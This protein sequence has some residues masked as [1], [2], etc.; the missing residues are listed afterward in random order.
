MKENKF[1]ELQSLSLQQPSGHQIEVE[2]PRQSLATKIRN[3]TKKQKK[4]KDAIKIPRSKLTIL[5]G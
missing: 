1:I 5:Q 2:L 3:K 4:Y